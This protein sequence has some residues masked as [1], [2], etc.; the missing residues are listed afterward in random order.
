MYHVSYFAVEI[1]TSFLKMTKF[2]QFWA[3]ITF[4]FGALNKPM[5]V[6]HL[7]NVNE[8]MISCQLAACNSSVYLVFQKQMFSALKIEENLSF[9][10]NCLN[11]KCKVSHMQWVS[12]IFPHTKKH[13]FKNCWCIYVILCVIS[14]IVCV[15]C[16]FG[17]LDEDFQMMIEM[18]LWQWFSRLIFNGYFKLYYIIHMITVLISILA[19]L[20]S[21]KVYIF[22]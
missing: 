20:K 11:F 21:K 7:S 9:S 16:H 3:W 2:P 22:L 12:G 1:Q 19:H 5:I 13:R 8:W 18:I 17:N 4:V 14:V 10:R 15:M 6:S